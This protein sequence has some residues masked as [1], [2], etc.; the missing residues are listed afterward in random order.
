MVRG[1]WWSGLDVLF[2][3]TRSTKMLLWC[4]RDVFWA[5]LG[6]AVPVEKW[7]WITFR[8]FEDEPGGR[9]YNHTSDRAGHGGG[10][11]NNMSVYRI[12]TQWINLGMANC[13]WK[14]LFCGQL[15]VQNMILGQN[16]LKMPF[17]EKAFLSPD[18][19]SLQK[20]TSNALV[21]A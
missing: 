2:L 7:I 21:D 16:L 19:N 18:S 17:S 1:W 4:R 13:G 10:Y 14:I 15:F 3:C 20:V 11:L 9:V 8:R 6:L 5:V 12:Y